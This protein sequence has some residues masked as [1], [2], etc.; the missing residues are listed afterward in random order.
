MYHRMGRGFGGGIFFPY[1]SPSL[2]LDKEVEVE[3]KMGMGWAS[4]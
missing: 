2:S 1:A 3:V 4:H